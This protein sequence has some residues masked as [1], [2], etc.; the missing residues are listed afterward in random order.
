MKYTFEE[1]QFAKEAYEGRIKVLTDRVDADMAEIFRL[2]ADK[3][4]IEK[5][6]EPE[7][8]KEEIEKNS[9]QLASFTQL[10]ELWQRQPEAN[11]DKFFDEVFFDKLFL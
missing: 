1:G 8:K 4:L 7:V 5:N 6:T 10:I 2:E 11:K 9:E 3:S